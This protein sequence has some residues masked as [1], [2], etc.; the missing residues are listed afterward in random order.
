MF[1]NVIWK[2]T[3][4]YLEIIYWNRLKYICLDLHQRLSS[5]VAALWFSAFTGLSSLSFMTIT[6]HSHNPFHKYSPS[7]KCESYHI[8]FTGFYLKVQIFKAWEELLCTLE[9]CFR[10]ISV[11]LFVGRSPCLMFCVVVVFAFFKISEKSF[12][13]Q[14][15]TLW[16][17]DFFTFWIFFDSCIAS[18]EQ[19]FH[20]NK[21]PC[22]NKRH[23]TSPNCSTAIFILS[24]G[25]PSRLSEALFVICWQCSNALYHKIIAVFIIS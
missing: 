24:W 23:L 11:W 21:H 10:F 16:T 8:S 25:I 3:Q 7:R 9:F 13:S 18:L 5:K 1:W 6:I 12:Y 20:H 14:V 2:L 15:Y 17:M 22:L 19:A 4:A